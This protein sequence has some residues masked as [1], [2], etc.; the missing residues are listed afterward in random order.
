M[1]KQFIGEKLKDN[2]FIGVLLVLISTFGLSCL[3]F[4]LFGYS[5][6][7][8]PYLFELPAGIKERYPLA[9]PLFPAWTTNNVSGFNNIG[10]FTQVSNALT[11]LYILSLGLSILGWKRI[12]KIGFNKYLGGAVTMFIAITG[13]VYCC[14]MLPFID[15]TATNW[16][17]EYPALGLIDFLGYWHHMA[18]PLIMLIIW[19]LPFNN[20]KLEVKKFTKIAL[21]FPI[22]YSVLTVLRG[23]CGGLYQVDAAGNTATWFPYPFLAPDRI[24]P[25]VTK[26]LGYTN[27]TLDIVFTVICYI[28]VMAIMFVTPILLAKINNKY[29]DQLNKKYEF[30][31]QKIN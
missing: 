9:E 16:V 14:I 12:Q 18:L 24:S 2:K 10:Y 20:E 28:L 13:L 1:K 22:V 6:Y 3:L 29:I 5:T 30:I 25:Y 8:R 31:D 17:Y 21:I 4:Q 15:K 11:D 26:L 27:D 23:F 19:Y 7:I